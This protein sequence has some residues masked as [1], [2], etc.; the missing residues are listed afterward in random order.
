MAQPA[1]WRITPGQ[2]LRLRQFDDESVLYNDLSGD[3][4]L[5]GDS[6][7]HLLSV[8]QHGPTSRGALLDALALAHGRERDA[9]FERDADALL[10]TLA[11]FFLIQAA[12][13]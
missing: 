11:G 6:A 2:A 12:P 13:C 1:A 8:L 4:H 10:A 9:A 3:T 5:L 7:V